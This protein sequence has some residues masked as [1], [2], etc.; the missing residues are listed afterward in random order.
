MDKVNNGVDPHTRTIEVVD[1]RR[2]ARLRPVHHR[3]E[4]IHSERNYEKTRP[5]RV[6][7]VEGANGDGRPHDER[8]LEAGE[9]VVESQQARSESD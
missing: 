1:Q 2:R 6:W 8:L 5:D 4:R 9:R 3:P 7:A